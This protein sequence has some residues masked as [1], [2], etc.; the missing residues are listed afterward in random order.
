MER[1]RKIKNR[2]GTHVAFCPDFSM[3]RFDNFSGDI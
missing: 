2:T 1:Y 3:M